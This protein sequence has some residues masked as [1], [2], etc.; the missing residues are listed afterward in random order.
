MKILCQR[1][2]QFSL[3]AHGGPA[4]STHSCFIFCKDS[5]LILCSLH[6]TTHGEL[7]VLGTL[8]VAFLPGTFTCLSE[9]NPVTQDLFATIAF[10][11]QPVN[12]DAVFGNGDYINLTW[13]TGF[14]YSKRERSNH[15]ITIIHL[16]Q[17][18]YYL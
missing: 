18:L 14:V 1:T 7:S 8:L 17:V 2:A 5:E 15:A 9:L 3:D 11:A 13:L 6:Q 12:S 16:I 4:R 10:W